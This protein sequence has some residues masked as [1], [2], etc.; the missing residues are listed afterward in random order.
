MHH[1]FCTYKSAALVT[2]VKQIQ[3]P[4]KT[5]HLPTTIGFVQPDT[6]RG[7]LEMTM[8]SRN[9]VPLRIFLIVPFGLFHIY[10]TEESNQK[11][12]C[13]R[14]MVSEKNSNHKV[15]MSQAR[16][17]SAKLELHP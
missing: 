5:T 12:W 17:Q 16:N 6:K 11:R 14:K 4:P 8:G 9:T 13:Q 2:A 7:T 1:H 10:T 15:A 3:Q